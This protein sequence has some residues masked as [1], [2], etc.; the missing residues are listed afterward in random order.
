[1]LSQPLINQVKLK[2]N[3]SE[4]YIDRIVLKIEYK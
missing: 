3:S 4:D 1:M 2:S